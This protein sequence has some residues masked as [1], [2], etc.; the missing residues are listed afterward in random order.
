VVVGAALATTEGSTITDAT[1][2]ALVDVSS[3]D[4]ASVTDMGVDASSANGESN[5]VDIIVNV[6]N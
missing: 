3:V 5:T 1:A 4:D 2:T 6:E